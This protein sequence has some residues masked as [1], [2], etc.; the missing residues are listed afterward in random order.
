M[1]RGEL[2]DRLADQL[3]RGRREPLHAYVSRK[4]VD[5]VH[6]DA[7]IAIAAASNSR[8]LTRQIFGETIG[9][10]PW[11]KPGCELG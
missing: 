5:H 11:K 1:I 6:P 4:H 9:W 3:V 10:L 7:I 2:D 8:E